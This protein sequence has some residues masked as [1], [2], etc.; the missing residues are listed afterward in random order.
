MSVEQHVVYQAVPKTP[1]DAFLPELAFEFTE[2]PDEVFANYI[3]RAID[4]LAREGNV[5][6]RQAEIHVQERIGNYLLEPPDCMD[7]VAVMKCRAVQA[8]GCCCSAVVRLTDEPA[9]M[10]QGLYTWYEH[11]NVIWFKPARHGDVFEVEFAVAPTFDACEVD[12]ILFEKY[13]DVVLT[14]VK[15][16]LYGISG[17][18]W[19][20]DQKFA[21]YTQ[22]FQQGIQSASLETLTGG[23][24]G[25]L[26]V[27]RPRV[28][29]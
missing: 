9:C 18:P 19:S 2:V 27:K 13:H 25:M 12:S 5:L 24:R 29:F 11:P 26:R 28:F 21:L 4:R 10:L 17:K 6:R 1:V 22:A 7:V 23:Q 20:S 8:N 14:G 15:S 16:Y 3:L